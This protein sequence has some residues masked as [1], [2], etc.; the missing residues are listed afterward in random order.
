MNIAHWKI[1]NIWTLIIFLTLFNNTCRKQKSNR[2]NVL[3]KIWGYGV[4]WKIGQNLTILLKL[5]EEKYVAEAFPCWK[6]YVRTNRIGKLF[7]EM[8]KGGNFSSR[9]YLEILWNN[10][11]CVAKLFGSSQKIC[12]HMFWLVN[13]ALAIQHI[14][15]FLYKYKNISLK[16]WKE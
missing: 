3:F 4:C 5:S 12:L 14:N 6:H 15:R 10:H 9:Q 1:L 11:P 16:I 13:L 8:S 7:H 2:T